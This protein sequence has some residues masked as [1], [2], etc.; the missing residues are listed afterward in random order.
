MKNIEACLSH[1]SDD[2]KTPTDL[3]DT[4]MKLNFIDTFKFQSTENELEND[5]YN[6]KLFINPP[7]SKMK[8]VSKWIE[9]QLENENTIALLIPARTDTQYF[10]DLAKYKP[11]IIFIKGRLHYNDSK[12]APFPSMLILFRK[13]IL[14][15]IPFYL[16]K[17]QEQLIKWLEKNLRGDNI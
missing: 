13:M 6:K 10:H 1:N 11:T 16:V 15:S 12:S 3:Y 14:I 8:E 5:Y 2:W 4:F 7:F 17:T 9:R